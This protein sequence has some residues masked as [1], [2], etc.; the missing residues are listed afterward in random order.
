MGRG[1][2][3]LR[4][5]VQRVVQKADSLN[6]IRTRAKV[7]RHHVRHRRRAAA[8]PAH[9]QDPIATSLRPGPHR[10]G[11]PV[12]GGEEHRKAQSR[13]LLGRGVRHLS[14][15]RRRV[16]SGDHQQHGRLRRHGH[17]ARAEPV[18]WHRHI[19]KLRSKG[20]LD[21]RAREPHQ[22]GGLPVRSSGRG[23]Q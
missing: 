8:L 9:L 19:R 11:V 12:Q 21:A 5:R 16:A 13:H 4:A 15:R 7:R 10:D 22:V 3:V 23:V 6:W 18:P 1:V 17:L 14:A 2:R 20:G